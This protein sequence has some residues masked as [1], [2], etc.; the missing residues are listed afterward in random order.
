MKNLFNSKL[1]N[2]LDDDNRTIEDGCMLLL[3]LE[4]NQIHYQNLLRHPNKVAVMKYLISELQKRLN[5]RLKDITHEEVAKMDEKVAV[6]VSKHFS[7]EEKKKEGTTDEEFRKGKRA[8]HDEL[9][10]E[11]QALYVENLDINR[12]MRE[13]H[14]KLRSISS[15]QVSCP[16]SERYPFLKELIALDKKYHE[17]WDAYDHYVVADA[18]TKVDDSSTPSDEEDGEK[19]PDEGGADEG[20]ADEGAAAE[21]AA[22]GAAA[23]GAAAEGAAEGEKPEAPEEA[24]ATKKKAAAKTKTAKAA[25]STKAKE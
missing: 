1:Q 22:E 12:R 21:G 24:A 23:E 25:K 17:N 7:H 4:N 6:I 2:W 20:A 14:L 10:D 8:D 5:I 15:S 16:D 19:V 13:V 11:I 18:P 3:Q 9:P